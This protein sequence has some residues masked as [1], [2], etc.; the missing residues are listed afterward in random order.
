MVKRVQFLNVLFVS[1]ALD[2]GPAGVH[3]QHSHVAATPAAPTRSQR[4]R[5]VARLARHALGV[6]KIEQISLV[7][8]LA[9]NNRKRAGVPESPQTRR[10]WM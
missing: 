8:V 9:D 7:L 4:H 3:D 2:D 10:K 5:R 1:V 6:V